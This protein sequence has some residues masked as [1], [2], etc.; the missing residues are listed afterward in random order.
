MTKPVSTTKSPANNI[1]NAD[2]LM[3]DTQSGCGRHGEDHGI[4]DHGYRSREYR[5]DAGPPTGAV[6][7]GTGSLPSV[8]ADLGHA[9]QAGVSSPPG[10]AT[11]HSLDVIATWKTH[12]KL[13]A[14]KDARY[15][16]LIFN[17][18]L[19]VFKTKPFT[20]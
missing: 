12:D 9:Y 7:P 19:S 10:H 15:S 14:S 17:N 1:R 8:H 16:Y 11:A 18:E 5:T 3:A 4:T 20:Y 6:S 2:A 13:R